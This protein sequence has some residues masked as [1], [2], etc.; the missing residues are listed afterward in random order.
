M[1]PDKGCDWSHYYPNMKQDLEED[2]PP[3][4]QMKLLIVTIWFD[5]DNEHYLQTSPSITDILVFIEKTP[6]GWLSTHQGVVEIDT[7]SSDL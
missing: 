1:H 4:L 6:V 7:Y 2:F 3:V 5:V